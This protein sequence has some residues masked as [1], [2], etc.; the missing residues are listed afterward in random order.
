ML[1]NPLLFRAPIRGR[2][3]SPFPVWAAWAAYCILA[4]PAWPQ[5]N[6]QRP[7]GA[8]NAN[9]SGCDDF[10][11]CFNNSTYWTQL[12]P[13]TGA[14]LAGDLNSTYFELFY[15]LSNLQA[16]MASGTG[17]GNGTPFC[18]IEL[19][20]LGTFPNARYFSV[21][22]NDMHYAGTQHM[23]DIAMD[24]ARPKGAGA[25]VNPYMPG[26]QYQP[27]QGY[28]VPVSFGSVPQQGASGTVAACIISPSE[29]DNLLDATQRHLSMDWN[30]ATQGADVHVP[31][32]AHVVDLPQHTLPASQGQDGSN[33]AGSIIVRSY[34]T[35]P[36]GPCTGLPGSGLSCPPP[37]CPGQ[38]CT[39]AN[40]VTNQYFIVRDAKSGCA[41]TA[42]YVQQHMLNGPF[43]SGTGGQ[44][45]TTAILST[46]DPTTSTSTAWMNYNMQIQHITNDNIT[47]QACYANGG[48]PTSDGYGNYSGPP[49]FVN[50]VAWSRSPEYNG[51]PGPDDS[52]VAGAISST[53]L[54]SLVLTNG[55]APC[56]DA[57]N[58]PD[59]Y[60]CLMRFRSQLPKMQ[61]TGLPNP[62]CLAPYDCSLS[63]SSQLRYMSMTFAYQASQPSG[64][65]F[66]V[67]D[68]DGVA[69]P[70]Q[71]GP[72]SLV[73]LADTAFATTDAN[74]N[75]YATL[76]VNVG[77]ILPSWLK[78]TSS[79]TG[80]LQG[81]QPVQPPG[82]P[83]GTVLP[84]YSVW[85]VTRSWT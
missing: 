59:G 37:P 30:T 50:R 42:A 75:E 29:N 38:S 62:P 34:L 84:E 9:P 48:Q 78:Q 46:Y 56:L 72:V 60:G 58:Y 54:Q 66:Y 76:L 16:W 63:S 25:F 67:A 69:P 81:V 57:D 45:P 51:S 20:M 11:N 33:T 64:N 18:P 4:I 1:A 22:D 2:K 5:T 41:Y 6:C 53:D 12:G 21:T 74:G 13:G 40:G 27:A 31:V 32:Q 47:P 80:A 73:S 52:Y 70:T 39:A 82:A 49:S 77:A 7:T 79:S 10:F 8:V 24:P 28:L 43:P 61:P 23:A 55:G 15:S 19:V 26:T 14:N 85:T 65:Q 68:P 71:N 3:R 44:S 83:S 17:T 36:Y 35:P